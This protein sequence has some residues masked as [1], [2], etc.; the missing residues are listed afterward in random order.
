MATYKHNTKI[1]ISNNLPAAELLETLN[2]KLKDTSSIEKDINDLLGIERLPSDNSSNED[3]CY[4]YN[5]ITH[6]LEITKNTSNSSS[7]KSKLKAKLK[8][9]V[10][11]RF[12]IGDFICLRTKAKGGCKRIERMY[13]I[14]QVVWTM[15]D[16]VIKALVVKQISGPNYNMFSM[17]RY[18]CARVHVKYEPGLQFLSMELPWI[19]AK[20]PSISDNNLK[21]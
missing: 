11:K 15:N 7:E 6:A 4:N 13:Q 3:I 20:S 18:D 5:P 2:T 21:N 16:L 17:N 14:K 10:H 8:S 19:Y 12:K 1:W 9:E